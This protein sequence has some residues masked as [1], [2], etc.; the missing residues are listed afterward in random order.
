[1]KITLLTME[2]EGDFAENIGLGRIKAFLN[3]LEYSVDIVY[4]KNGETIDRIISRIDFNCKLFGISVY[5]K[6]VMIAAEVARA[7]KEKNEENIVVMGS[8][9][10]SIYYRELL[11]D[12]RLKAVDYIILGDGEYIFAEFC[13]ALE[14]KE[15]ITKFAQKHPHIAARGGLDGKK[16][17]ALNVAEL[18]LPDRSM[19]IEKRVLHAYIC[20]SHGCCN[21]CSFCA[22]GS[23]YNKWN[24]RTAESIYAEIKMLYRNTDVI[25]FDFTGGSF[26]DPGSLGKEKISKLCNYILEDNLKITLKCYLRANSF[27]DN[28]EDIRLLQ[29]MYNAGF[30]VVFV[31]IESGNEQDLEIYNK[32]TTVKQNK[33]MLKRL[34]DIGIYCGSFGFIMLNPYSTSQTLKENFKFLVEMKCHNFLAYTSRLTAYIGTDITKRIIE[35]GL[36]IDSE[37][38]L[39]GIQYKY[40]EPEIE[41]IDKF[42][43]KNFYSNKDI[44][45]LMI[46]TDAIPLFIH[47]LS[48]FLQDGDKYLT[49]LNLL[50]N[51]YADLFKD[52]FR[53]LYEKGDMKLCEKNFEAFINEVKQ[54]DKKLNRLKNKFLKEFIAIQKRRRR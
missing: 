17:C 44:E 25:F 22:Q 3:N 42:I 6:S 52:Y 31:G 19:I 34:T 7:I 23:Y 4:F 24:G 51:Q 11:Q 5:D 29:K 54:L 43:K 9:Y 12:I 46:N 8:K 36:M 32:K 49:M 14:K 1:M 41:K 39:H 53:N 33:E 18:P 38:V 40:R 10:A 35:D 48:D 2:F 15:N 16:S 45:R 37:D 28:S 13:K 20:D 50:M 30:K 26:E 27:Q 21:R 47:Q